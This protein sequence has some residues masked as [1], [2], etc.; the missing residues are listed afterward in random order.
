M[1]ALI[2]GGGGF[3]GSH[4]AKRLHDRGDSVYV[5]G[6]K[7]YSFLSPG[8]ECIQS[9]LRDRESV[10]RACQDMDTVFHVGAMT[11]IWGKKKDFHEI[12]VGGTK[13]IIE[14]C[15]EHGVEKLIYTSSPSVVFNHGNLENVDETTPYADSFFCEYPKSK[16]IAERLVIASNGNNGLQTVSLRPH[17]IWGPGDPH[18][19]PRIIE[20][21]KM[22][23]L[24]QVGDGKNK[25]DIIYIDNAVEGHI[26]ACDSLSAGKD[27]AGKCYFLN[28][29]EAVFLW[30]WINNL[31]I[32]L[33][34]PAV[35]KSISFS[36]AKAIGGFLEM[37]YKVFRLSGEPR[38]TRFVAEQLATSHYFD[39]SRATRELNYKPVVSIEEGLNRLVESLVIRPAG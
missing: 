30:E 31:L 29:G 12:N 37:V 35:K 21:A 9:D 1:R 19:V 38:M 32:R 26:L 11:G 18:L 33:G 16:A 20:S 5:L 27:V 25:V 28:D 17:L 24:V 22:N 8:I 10:V 34:I 6:R 3:L 36:K 2:T 13:N 7:K 14:G 39:I 23:R 15:Q 4:I